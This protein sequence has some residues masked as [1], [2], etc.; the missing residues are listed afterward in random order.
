[1]VFYIYNNTL[2]L[3]ILFYE[4]PLNIAVNMNTI[5]MI[6]IIKCTVNY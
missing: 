3:S 4:S 5:E 1:M 6:R 2:I